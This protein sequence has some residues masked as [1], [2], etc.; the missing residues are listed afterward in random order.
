ML[1]LKKIS[2][3]ETCIFFDVCKYR[4]NLESFLRDVEDYYLPLVVEVRCILYRP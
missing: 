3:C 2:Y 1:D 4:A